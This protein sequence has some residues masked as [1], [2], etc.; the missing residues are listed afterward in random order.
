VNRLHAADGCLFAL[1]HSFRL[2][3][4]PE[5]WPHD[6]DVT[7]KLRRQFASPLDLA[8]LVVAN[9]NRLLGARYTKLRKRIKVYLKEID[10]VQKRREQYKVCAGG[11]SMTGVWLFLTLLRRAQTVLRVTCRADLDQLDQTDEESLAA[12]LKTT[13]KLCTQQQD[14]AHGSA[15]LTMNQFQWRPYK[16]S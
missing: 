11:G 2:E 1:D 6:A 12:E 4:F 9:A 13:Q 15:V 3:D 7:P 10:D 16:T 5:E 14:H 8:C